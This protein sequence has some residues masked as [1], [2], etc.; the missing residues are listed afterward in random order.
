MQIKDCAKDIC[1]KYINPPRTTNFAILFLPTEGLY[2]EVLRQPGLFEQLQREYKVTLAGPTTLAALLNAL[3]MGFRS[4]AIEKRSSEVWQILGAVQN[5]YGR[6]N[7][8]VERLAKQLTSAVNSVDSL[9]QRTRVMA[10]TLK[11]VE[12]LPNPALLG[13]DS[14]EVDPLN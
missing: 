4:L 7:D 1:E 12:A 11:N 3:Q 14:E 2:A 5:E 6:Y 9:G 13:L 10:R 8:V